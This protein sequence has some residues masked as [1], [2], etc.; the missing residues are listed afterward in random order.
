MGNLLRVAWAALTS[1]LIL[2]QPVPVVYAMEAKYSFDMPDI[3]ELLKE[4]LNHP[5][6][7]YKSVAEMPKTA[8]AK[9]S[10]DI[11]ELDE[12]LVRRVKKLFLGS[13]EALYIL[14]MCRLVEAHFDVFPD[15]RRTVKATWPGYEELCVPL[16]AWPGTRVVVG[17]AGKIAS[18]GAEGDEV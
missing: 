12:S 18:P 6:Y 17:L 8:V 10:E 4:Y 11:S 16:L 2:R 1:A 13:Y 14:G 5:N 3:P 15:D 9:V 7:K